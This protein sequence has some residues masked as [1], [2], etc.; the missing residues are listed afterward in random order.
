MN[1]P[2]RKIQW[3][4]WGGLILTISAILAAFVAAPSKGKPLPVYG[5]LP[6]FQLTDQN[7]R[8]TTLES[9]RGQIWI[10]DVI[11][12]R[13]AGQC[14][15]MSAHMK[16]LQSA[17]PPGSPVKL[18]SFTTDPAFDTPAVLKKYAGRF[19]ARDGQWVF[20][21]GDKAA[22]RRATVDGLKLTVVDKAPGDQE[23][24]TDFFIHSA[25]FV[26]IDKSGRIRGYYDGETPEAVTQVLAAAQSLARE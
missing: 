11:F 3:A 12:T 6:P 14:L 10:A 5:A 7:N 17:L 22:L 9:L 19:G 13:C 24:A 21:T 8:T 1:S 23:N 26:L 2:D 25:K 4:V 16:D 15:I 18:L 20:L